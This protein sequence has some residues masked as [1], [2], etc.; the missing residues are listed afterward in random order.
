MVM[1]KHSAAEVGRA[2]VEEGGNP[3]KVFEAVAITWAESKWSDEASSSCCHGVWAL[4]Q[5]YYDVNCARNLRCATR[6]A[7]KTSKNGTDW[8]AWDVHPDSQGRTHFASTSPAIKNYE[9][10][11]KIAKRNGAV[12]KL[13]GIQLPFGGPEIGPGPSINPIFPTEGLW[14]GAIGGLGDANI[15][16]LSDAA[17]ALTGVN[18]FFTGLGELILTPEGWVRSGKLVGGSI[19]VFWGLRVVV[20]VSTGTDPVK[21]AT[22]TA[23]KAVETAAVVATVK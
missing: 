19:L 21:A 5:D 16:L 14:K 8:S 9:R 4:H 10:G 22:D 12:K 18:A 13:A 15:P 6:E 20:R 1:A 2:W 7:I 11:L 3:A 17:N 23:K